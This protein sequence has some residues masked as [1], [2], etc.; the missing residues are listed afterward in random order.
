MTWRLVGGLAV[1]GTVIG[2]CVIAEPPADLPTIP[3]SPPVIVRSGVVPP[4]NAV[5]TSWPDK[6]FVPVRLSDTRQS[7]IAAYFT[8]WNTATGSGFENYQQSDPPATGVSTNPRVLEV[9]ISQPSV[10]CH[11][12]EV[13][14]Q[15]NSQFVNINNQGDLHNPPAGGDS[16]LWFYSPGGDLAG[17]PTF[18]LDGGGLT[19]DAATVEQLN[20]A[21]VTFP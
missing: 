1:V 13:V 3:A 21:G 8:D 2:A 5:L 20:D 6:F 7:V 10:S 11:V 12:I 16:I 18:N 15:L 17:C 19:P 9:Q 14:V 4:P